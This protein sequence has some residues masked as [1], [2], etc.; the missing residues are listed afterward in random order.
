MRDST[1][2]VTGIDFIK[3]TQALLRRKFQ[4]KNYFEEFVLTSFDNKFCAPF[5]TKPNLPAQN[6]RSSTET[7]FTEAKDNS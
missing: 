3:E 2:I 6:L 5:L 4:S 1:K 7:N